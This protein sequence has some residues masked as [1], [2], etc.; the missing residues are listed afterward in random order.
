MLAHE[1]SSTV[2]HPSLAPP[3]PLHLG[4]HMVTPIPCPSISGRKNKKCVHRG[5]SVLSTEMGGIVF[6]VFC[7]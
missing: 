2:S 7:F 4:V 6:I 5:P 3:S 1:C